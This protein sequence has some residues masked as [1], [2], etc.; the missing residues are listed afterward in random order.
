MLANRWGT[1]SMAAMFLVYFVVYVWFVMLGFY[2]LHSR[3]S[4]SLRMAVILFRLQV[5]CMCPLQSQLFTSRTKRMRMTYCGSGS[6]STSRKEHSTSG[7]AAICKVSCSLAGP[8]AHGW[9]ER[10][11]GPWQNE[12]LCL[13]QQQ[14]KPQGA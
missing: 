13:R 11:P 12:V 8:S 1:I 5:G 2:Q 14:H 10:R 3:P 4:G 7:T 9:G 6:S